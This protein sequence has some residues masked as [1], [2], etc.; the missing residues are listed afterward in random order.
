MGRSF[1]LKLIIRTKGGH[2]FLGEWK[3]IKRYN[4][5]T[6]FGK[7]TSEN[8]GKWRDDFNQSLKYGGANEHLGLKYWIQSDLEI[9]NQFTNQVVCEHFAPKFETIN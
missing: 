2:H 3:P 1:K 9:Y 4:Q 5:L 6:G 7:P 8:L